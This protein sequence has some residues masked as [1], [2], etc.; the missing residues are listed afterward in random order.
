MKKIIAV[1]SVAACSGVWASNA[2]LTVLGDPDDLSVNTIE[3]DPIPVSLPGLQ[4]IMHV[5]V[6]RSAPRINWD[7]VPY[8][9]YESK[10]LFECDKH[11]ARYVSIVFYLQPGW[12]GVSHRTSEYSKADARRMEFRDVKPNPTL[13][14]IRA[15]CPTAIVVN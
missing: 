5:R 12:T 3:V 4:R 6:S 14:I 7:G 8:R 15:A 11:K 9:S 10:V 2:W 13:R 1:L